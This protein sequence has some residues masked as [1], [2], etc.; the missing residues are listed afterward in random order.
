MIWWVL[1]LPVRGIRGAVRFLRA[2]PEDRPLGDV[3]TN[4]SS[5]PASLL[6]HIDDLRKHLLRILVALAL[7]IGVGFFFT[8]QIL[9]YLARPVGGLDVLRAIDV[10]E[11]IGVY[12]QVAMLGGFTLAV[13]YIAFELWLFIAPALYPRTRF[14]GLAS[15]PFVAVLFVAG[16]AFAYFILLPPA[17]NFL[18]HFTGIAVAPRPSTTIDFVI[19]VLFWSGVAFQFPLIMYVLT[20]MHLIKPRPLL[21]QWRIAIVA[22]AIL[23][24][25]ITP[26]P[27][28]VNMSLVMVPMVLLYFIGVGLSFL[29]A[30]GHKER[31]PAAG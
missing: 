26:T 27:D 6:E 1:R 25:A 9:G 18:L 21:K 28:P 20:A 31:Q 2:E 30:S 5:Q 13:P 7:T 8:Q 10:T 3:L 19:A 23:A 29:A 22:I 12:M 15:I 24:A 4:V 16:M 17:M 11:P 14:M